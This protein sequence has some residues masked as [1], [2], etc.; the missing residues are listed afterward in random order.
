MDKEEL[1][2]D[3]SSQIN[4]RFII[5]F[6]LI[7]LGIFSFEGKAQIRVKPYLIPGDDQ[8]N[9]RMTWF[10]EDSSDSQVLIWE[11]SSKDT[12]KIKTSGVFAHELYYSDLEES[13]R[14]NYP[15]MY[16][17]SNWKHSVVLRDLKTSTEYEYLL[18]HASETLRNSFR[19]APNKNSRK[20]IRFAAMADSETDYEGRFT[21]RNWPVGKQTSKSSGR[22]EGVKNYPITETQG[23]IANLE[24]VEKNQPEF[25]VLAG[26]IVQGGAYQRAWDEFFFHTA[27][28]FNDI[29]GRIPLFPAIGNWE[30]FGARN[31]GYAPASIRNARGK[32]KSYFSLP[33]NQSPRYQD[34]YYRVD[35]GFVTVITLDS[36]NGLPDNTDADTNVNINIETYPGVDIP[37]INPGSAQWKWAEAQLKDAREKGQI[38]FVQFHHIPYSGGGH[39]LPLTAEGSS[40]QAGVPMRKYTP[41]FKKYGVVAV[42]CGH[43]EF[44]EHSV[45][46][47]VHFWDVGI[48][49][50]GLGRPDEKDPRK[51]N[52]FS[53]WTAHNDA[54]EY[55]KGNQLIEGGKHYGHLMIEVIPKK[56]NEF[57]VKMKPYHIFPVLDEN[58]NLIR[59]DEKEY[60]YEV[61]EIRNLN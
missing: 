29:L 44:L 40:G 50:D 37:D 26:D 23:F 28:K 19:T 45:V 39:I 41:M 27:G 59:I 58:G 22:P 34:A 6:T 30:N 21:N 9:Y 20:P 60:E 56:N 51:F 18:K 5:G 17:G 42:L 16:K 36:S 7:F 43:N 47:G 31:G 2:M 38:I 54:P 48:A 3:L 32:Y 1:E 12:L 57:E 14:E 25:I 15:D 4:I 8:S 13:E 35:Y 61:S 33:D 52:E 49:G 11:K 10:T 46:E 24:F 55:W 53:K